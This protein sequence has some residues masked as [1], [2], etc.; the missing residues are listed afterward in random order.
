MSNLQVY[1]R[2]QTDLQQ[3]HAAAMNDA[4]LRKWTLPQYHHAINAALQ[5]WG[6][7]VM[8]PVEYIIPGGFQTGVYEYALPDYMDDRIRVQDKRW[9]GVSFTPSDTNLRVWQDVIAYEVYPDSD[10]TRVLR[11][12][13]NP[14]T[15]DGRIIWHTSNGPVPVEANHPVVDATGLTASA[16]SVGLKSAPVVSRAGYVK[17]NDE[18]MQYAGWT[19]GSGVISLDNLIRGV[20]GT[21]AA[22]HSENDPVTWGIAV[23]KQ[24]YFRQMQYEVGAYLHMLRL[25]VTA[26][27]ERTGHQD[28]FRIYKQLADELLFRLP[29]A[30]RPS[31][32][33]RRTAMGPGIGDTSYDHIINIS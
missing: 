17:I 28:Q 14:Y 27:T 11:L 5:T 21:T 1:V 12:D 31:Q 8:Y 20:S 3:E 19:P 18:W 10:G 2:S 33:L 29:P 6:T 25:N 15:T 32:R 4:D 22:S 7:R 9:I 24:E 13:Y 23:H 30:S 26:P 16:T